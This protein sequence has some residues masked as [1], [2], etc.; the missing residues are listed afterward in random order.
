MKQFLFAAILLLSSSMVFGQFDSA[1][2]LGTVRDSTGAVVAGA[3]VTLT[4]LE[5]GISA[6]AS[7]NGA[8]EYEFPALRVGQYKV[9]A[10]K[11]GFTKG[12]ADNVA[13]NVSARQRVDLTLS[14]AQASESVEVTSAVSLVETDSSQRGQI[15]TKSQA[16]ELP[17]NGRE[18]SQLVLLTSGVRQ[19]A[20]GTAS[21]STNREG[22][23]NV[24]G[25]RSTFN[26]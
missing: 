11:Q 19:S 5:T 25:L 13:V 3:N 8:G 14:P 7:T 16:V 10:E 21:I 12:A 15:V 4:N 22:S 2:V 24:N 17:L 26:N 1:S 20:V 23:F 6:Q 18:Y 9:T